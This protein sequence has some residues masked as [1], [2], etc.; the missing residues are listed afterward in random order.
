DGNELRTNIGPFDNVEID[1]KSAKTVINQDSPDDS[2]RLP[3]TVAQGVTDD[4][5]RRE[6]VRKAAIR[7]LSG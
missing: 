1:R 3:T 4:H 5:S 7:P 6:P 2:S